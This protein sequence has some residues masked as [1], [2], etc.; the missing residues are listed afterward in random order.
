MDTEPTLWTVR[1]TGLLGVA[2]GQP[3]ALAPP[4]AYWPSGPDPASASVAPSHGAPPARPARP[5]CGET[6]P[7]TPTCTPSTTP[8]MAHLWGT[9][10]LRRSG[11]PYAVRLGGAGHGALHSAVGGSLHLWS[12]AVPACAP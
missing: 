4:A 10:R 11:T 3:T 12:P 7:L 5:T 9:L 1:S 6:T 2:R 8:W